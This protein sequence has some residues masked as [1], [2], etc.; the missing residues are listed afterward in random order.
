[1]TQRRIA[2]L[3]VLLSFFGLGAWQRQ[4]LWLLATTKLVYLRSEKTVERRRVKRS[5]DAKCVDS[6]SWW[7]E[8][9]MMSSRLHGVGFT[10]W[11]PDGKVAV[12]WYPGHTSI[13]PPWRWGVSDQADPT[14]PWVIAGMSVDEWWDSQPNEIKRKQ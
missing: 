8:T 13:K 5:D 9:G 11:A 1:M 3:F 14:A 12:Q 2:I 6:E 4:A 10:T 7:C